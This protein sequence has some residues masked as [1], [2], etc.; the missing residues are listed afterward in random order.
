V[1]GITSDAT[2]EYRVVAP[3]S[4]SPEQGRRSDTNDSVTRHSS[5]ESAQSRNE[6]DLGPHTLIDGGAIPT[7]AVLMPRRTTSAGVVS[8]ASLVLTSGGYEPFHVPD[9]NAAQHLLRLAPKT[10]QL[11]GRAVG[12][13]AM[14]P[15]E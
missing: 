14:R 1:L 6:G 5:R 11:D 15:S 7:S 9:V 13:V 10:R 4:L 8:L 3:L 12:T 2:D